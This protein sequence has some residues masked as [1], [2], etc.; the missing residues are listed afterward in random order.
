LG[1]TTIGLL[2]FSGRYPGSARILLDTVRVPCPESACRIN[3][4]SMYPLVDIKLPATSP[5]AFFS[6]LARFIQ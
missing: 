2:K 5:G 3:T 1:V 6:P 4:H